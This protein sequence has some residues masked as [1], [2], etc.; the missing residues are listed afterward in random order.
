M[1][2]LPRLTEN[3]LEV[4][5]MHQD[6]DRTRRITRIRDEPKGWARLGYDGTPSPWYLKVPAD[7]YYETHRFRRSYP[8]LS[9]GELQL[10]LD[11][12]RI[13]AS[14]PI[15]LVTLLNTLQFEFEL[16]RRHFGLQLTDKGMDL[17]TAK[18]HIEVQHAPE[19]VIAAI[20]RNGGS[21]STAYYD[22]ASLNAMVNT[23]RFFESGR[24][25]PRRQLPPEDCLEYYSDAKHRGYL[26]PA[27][28]VAKERALLAQKYGYDLPK[29]NADEVQSKDPRQVF[30][31]LAPGTVVDLKGKRFLRPKDEKLK[32]YYE[33]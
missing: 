1:R 24:P 18:V 33:S 16:S 9:L 29:V 3:T 27:S 21:V 15:D 22:L 7:H 32:A 17:F 2:S 28:A 20:E 31:G 19:H 4:S 6:P 13:D 8:P 12:N 25:I 10:W 30:Y 26:A 14:R 23:T 11:S 5:P